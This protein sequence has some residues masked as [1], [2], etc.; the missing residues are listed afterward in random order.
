[1]HNTHTHVQYMLHT[2]KQSDDDDTLLHHTL[3]HA[4]DLFHL[5]VCIFEGLCTELLYNSLSFSPA[6]LPSIPYNNSFLCRLGFPYKWFF[7]PDLELSHVHKYVSL[8]AASHSIGRLYVH[9]VLIGLVLLFVHPI[10]V[11]LV[12]CTHRYLVSL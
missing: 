6:L 3:S 4:R 9:P 7:V 10:L 8:H 1:M 11:G 2:I 5:T 12:L